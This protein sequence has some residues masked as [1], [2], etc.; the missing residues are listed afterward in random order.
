MADPRPA[1][2]KDGKVWD[3]SHKI[4][5][6]DRPFHRIG[7]PS[8]N[9][10]QFRQADGNGGK[11]GCR[12]PGI[13]TAKMLKAVPAWVPVSTSQ[14]YKEL[15]GRL[16]RSF[17]TWTD[18]PVWQ[19][20]RWYDWNFHV[21]PAT[22]SLFT[23]AVDGFKYLRGL[24]NQ[25]GGAGAL[26]QGE[27]M[28][29]EWDTGA[30]GSKPGAIFG[31]DWCWPMTG[32]WV[33]LAGQ[34]IYDCGHATE[35]GLMRSELHP[36]EAVAT[37]RWEAVKFD[38]QSKSLWPKDIAF[39]PT[40]ETLM[41]PAIQFMFF[42]S[43]LGGF[44]DFQPFA[45]QQHSY[46]FV[47]DLPLVKIV[48]SPAPIQPTPPFNTVVVTS[49]SLLARFDTTQFQS[50][51]SGKFQFVEPTITA[52][53][54]G[55]GTAP[56]QVIIE[57]PLKS[58]NND[59]DSYGFIVSLGYYDVQQEL[60]KSVYECQVIFENITIRAIKPSG[61]WEMNYGVNGRWFRKVLKPIKTIG[62]VQDLNTTVP[63][64]GVP[65]NL[66]TAQGGPIRLSAHGKSIRAVGEYFNKPQAART[67]TLTFKGPAKWFEDIDQP[68][69]VLADF[70]QR[71]L[72]G[73]MAS[74][75]DVENDAIGVTDMKI[76]PSNTAFRSGGKAVLAGRSLK[77]L[78]DLA[79]LVFD[80][81]E[82]YEL[83]CRLTI[84]P[85]TVP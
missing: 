80:V 46:K 62:E 31:V 29:C 72:V 41:L 67:L 83:L 40:S 15:E 4:W 12:K 5:D 61:N 45:N 79:E 77:E 14:Q 9:T 60:A 22:G 51:A 19:W 13:G 52:I 2:S 73:M 49:P 63:T 3:D 37:A 44:M 33:W 84:K 8:F 23:P 71:D 10:G 34:W 78:E 85:Q 64:F 65:M 35:S 48:G 20:H 57:I 53:D 68:N 18:F 25:A 11:C 1:D 54:P 28:E 24:G 47:V 70:V 82:D 74:T 75:L 66:P 50:Q 58:L 56:T 21:E 16:V 17:Q 36:C 7:S 39:V 30:F 27:T 59:T 26:V 43:R 69:D 38:A 76:S 42:A 32:Q 55:D 81:G 6:G